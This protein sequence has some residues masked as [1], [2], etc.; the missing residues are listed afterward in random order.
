MS[1]IPR[2]AAKSLPVHCNAEEEADELARP[3]TIFVIEQSI[4]KLKIHTS[5]GADCL[6][7]ELYKCHRPTFARIPLP[8]FKEA[9]NGK[10]LP[11]SFSSSI[12][13]RLPKQQG[14]KEAKDFRR[15]SLLNMDQKVLAHVLANRIKKIKDLVHDNQYAYIKGRSIHNPH[16]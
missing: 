5:P 3:I 8:T 13:S 6:T 4:C 9:F 10:Q 2:K 14:L 12:I 11:K 7:A 15:V 1:R 16:T